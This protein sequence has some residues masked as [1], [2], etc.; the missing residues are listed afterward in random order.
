MGE[1]AKLQAQLPHQAVLVNRV[2]ADNA[3]PEHDMANNTT[4]AHTTALH[5]VLVAEPGSPTMGVTRGAS[6]SLVLTVRNRG[7]GANSKGHLFGLDSILL[8]KRRM[9]ASR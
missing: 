5:S 2:E 1:D 4:E 9:P 3:L 7:R 6:S 8:K